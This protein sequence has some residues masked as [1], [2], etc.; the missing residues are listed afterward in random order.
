MWGS[1]RSRRASGMSLVEVAMAIAI[2]GAFAGMVTM[3]VRGHRVRSRQDVARKDITAIAK[4]LEAFRAANSRYPTCEEGL[5]VLGRATRNR[6]DPLLRGGAV[7]PWGRPYRYDAPP[8]ADRY[9]V[10][11]LGADGVEGGE[12]GD[13]DISSDELGG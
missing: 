4:A 11:C 8:S 9:R 3:S 1:R 2:L 6:T 12:G 10:V 13:R 7:D 5:G